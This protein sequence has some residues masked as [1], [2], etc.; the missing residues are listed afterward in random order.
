MKD[1][2]KYN[3]VT[4][5]KEHNKKI[6]LVTLIAGLGIMTIIIL[7]FLFEVPD[8]SLFQASTICENNNCILEFYQ[9]ENTTKNISFIKI[10]KKKY[11]I[12]NITYSK[13][14][15]DANGVIYQKV[16]LELKKYQAKEN[17][18]VELKIYK[19]KVK[20]IKKIMKII[21]ER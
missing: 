17:E 1:E 8:V 2:L 4:Y 6:S 10:N 11:E 20:L 21:L 9:S 18:I 5:T 19:D 12:Q 7:L 3:L 16:S 15:L 14:E 13:P